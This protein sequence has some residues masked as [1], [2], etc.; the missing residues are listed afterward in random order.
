[1][2][3]GLPPEEDRAQAG[4]APAE[5][6][7]WSEWLNAG[8]DGGDAQQRISAME[9]LAS[10]RDRV[11]AGAGPLGG[12]AL[13]D[14][15]CGEGLIGVGAIEVV[16]STG[17]VVFSDISAPLLEQVERTVQEKGLTDRASY[18]QA[19]APDLELI[20]N[21]S[22][23]VVTTRSV[24]IYV[25]DKAAAFREMF[26]VLRP[27]GR[28]SLFEP[29]NRPMYPEPEDRFRGYEISDVREL[30]DEVKRVAQG[31]A[32]DVNA[33][34]VNFDERD[35][36]RLAASAGF[37]PIDVLMQLSFGPD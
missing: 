3:T 8:R 14:I 36:L 17:A 7:E 23:D 12:K 26:R 11:L 6:D 4:T 5:P 9:M 30:A 35:L 1:M 2:T 13:L 22:V 21:E 15:G 10:V 20:P 28:I 16:G 33:A 31:I 19:A 25:D 37:E 27:G 24:L 18:V 34:M 32:T 29:V